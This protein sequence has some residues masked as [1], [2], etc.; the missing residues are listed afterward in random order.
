MK[1]LQL[2]KDYASNNENSWL[3]HK[4]DLLEVEVNSKKTLKE[5]LKDDVKMLETDIRNNREADIEQ[6]FSYWRVHL[7]DI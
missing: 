5:F 4:L 1:T 2:L 3:T 6:F 7:K